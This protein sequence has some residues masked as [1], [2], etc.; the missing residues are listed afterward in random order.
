M[1]KK[2]WLTLGV[3][4]IA[5]VLGVGV[6]QTNASQA[7]PT[8]TFDEI[9]ELVTSQYPGTITELELD[10]DANGAIYKVEVMNEEMEYELK[11]DGHSG[12]VITLK[13]KHVAAKERASTKEMIDLKEKEQEK[14]AMEQE[15]KAAQEQAEKEREEKAQADK[16]QQEKEQA[17]RKKH[18]EETKITKKE[19]EE[20]EQKKEST[21]TK[22]K[23]KKQEKNTVID[24][25]KAIDIALEQFPG[26]VEE[27]ELDEED[28]RLIYEIEI[29]ADGEEAEFEID[30]YTGEIIVIEIEDD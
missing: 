8:L 16:E 21:S 20:K 1:T 6:Y 7:E 14:I 28:G 15:E 11:M 10:T 3:I 23:E 12:E 26:V 17:E 13:E 19:S 5:V 27:V 9:K 29:T 4:T 22:S 25:N 24:V 2:I 30:A 18:E